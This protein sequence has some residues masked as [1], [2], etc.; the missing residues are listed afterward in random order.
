MRQQIYQLLVNRIPGIR[1]RYLQY[2]QRG[3]TR[4]R[5][6]LYLLWLNVQYYVFFCRSL[7]APQRFPMYE[8]KKLYSEG[9]ESSLSVWDPPEAFADRLTAY[10]V[11]S[12]DVF[13]TL[14]FRPFA[15]PA[16]VFFGVWFGNQ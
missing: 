10:D 2:R 11:I 6:L 1:D 3:K 4:W 16:D 7:G 8:E 5:A 9:S 15:Q 12:F 14:L 13:D